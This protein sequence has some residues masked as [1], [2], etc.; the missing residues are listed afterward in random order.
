TGLLRDA[1]GT[2]W[3]GTDGTGLQRYDEASD[4]FEVFAHD[5]T[6]H[7]SLSEDV[8]E[9]LFE[10]RQG[11][12]WIGTMGS[13]LNVLDAPRSRVAR[14]AL[15]REPGDLAAVTVTALLEDH[16]GQVWVASRG[17]LHRFDPA[18]GTFAPSAPPL[19]VGY[20]ILAL[21]DDGRGSIWAAT[22]RGGL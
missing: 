12:L 20:A 7:D 9:T 13:G 14:Y 22:Y 15:P 3:V 5:E 11:Q 6:D 1:T 17:A 2:L 10:D 4:S 8:V 16:A 21:L 19:H 18:R